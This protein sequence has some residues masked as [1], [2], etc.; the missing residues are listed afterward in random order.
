MVETGSDAHGLLA[1]RSDEELNQ[2]FDDERL[3]GRIRN[4]DL[5]VVRIEITQRRI[6]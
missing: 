3:A 6:S 4:D 1:G 2:F 5:A